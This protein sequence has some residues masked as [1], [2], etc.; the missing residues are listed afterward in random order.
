MEQ[1]LDKKI[2]AALLLGVM[3]DMIGFGNGVTEFN[4]D[5]IFSEDNYGE[6][7]VKSGADYSSE[8]VF[9]F[10]ADGGFYSH[11]KSTYTVSDDT[12]MLLAN[13]TAIIKWFKDNTES[14]TDLDITSLINLIRL[15]Y[16]KLIK[17]RLDLD[18]FERVYK[19]GV[20]T[21]SYLKKIMNGDDYKKFAY[22]DKAGGSGGSMRSMIFGTVFYKKEDVLKLIEC[23]IESTFL[24]HPNAIAF[25]GSIVVALMTSFAMRGIEPNRWCSDMLEIIDSDIIDNYMMTHHE[26]RLSFYQRDKKIFINK[27]RNYM[28]D[29]FDEFDYTYKKSKIM[30]YPAQRSI[31]Y[32]SFSNKKKNIYP[33]AGGDDS[34]I[35]AYDCLMD[36]DGSWDKLVFYSMLHVGDSDTTGMIAGYLYG[37]YYGLNKVYTKMIDNMID[38]KEKVMSVSKEI[39]KIVV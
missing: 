13:A 5:N 33:G 28:E 15:E 11:P 38:H 16:I 17:E 3:G 9:N 36:A 21:I 6:N 2:N 19:G 4:E 35:I 26:T 22:D 8:L 24:T 31:Y 7:F 23:C 30:K 27:W 12:I 20:T 32:H 14:D 29:K 34:A 1:K 18:K 37:S 39:S 10:I 25:L